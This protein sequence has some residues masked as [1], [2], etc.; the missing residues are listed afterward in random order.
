LIRKAKRRSLIDEN[1]ALK[2]LDELRNL[3]DVLVIAA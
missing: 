2:L 1:T 3:G